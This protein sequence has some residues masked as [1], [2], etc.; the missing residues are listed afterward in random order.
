[1]YVGT[2]IHEAGLLCASVRVSLHIFIYKLMEGHVYYFEYE[3]VI[4]AN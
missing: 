2:Q 1:M 3:I 4:H